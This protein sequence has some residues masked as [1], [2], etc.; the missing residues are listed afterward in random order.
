VVDPLQYLEDE[1]AELDRR[2]LL[3]AQA[4]ALGADAVSFCSNDYLGLAHLP[5]P[6]VPSGAGAS[7]LIAGEREEHRA[8]ERELA[9]WLAL[10]D[11]LVFTSG[12]AANVGVL[13]ALARPG[14]LIVS[15]ALNHASIIDGARLSRARVAVVPHL[16]VRAIDDVL[17][18]REEPRAFVVVESYFSMDADGPDLSALR[19]VCDARGAAMIVDEAHALGVLGP[20]GRGRCAEAN[21]VPDVL[22]GTLG[23]ALGAQG[24]FAAGRSTVRSWLWNRARSFV[25]ST[26][27]APSSAAAASRSLALVRGEPDLG[28]RVLGLASRMRERLASG[29]V[30]V[31]GFGHVV[32]VVLGEPDRAMA[33]AE[34]LRAA[35]VIVQAVRPP[36]VP[37]GSSRIR[38]TVTAS[39]TPALVDTAADA[40]VRALH[41]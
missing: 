17:A 1:L 16:D 39:H 24:A 25:F 19:K 21:V 30:D 9:T 20:G 4:T 23:K 22:V 38:L 28:R 36:T 14:D 31:L 34:R 18:R 37:D 11:A 26:G 15:D 35:G 32:P 6:S 27:L 7:R 13:S 3:R 29:R 10:D 41:I 40:V 33:I 5:A 8:L 12:Y 2:G